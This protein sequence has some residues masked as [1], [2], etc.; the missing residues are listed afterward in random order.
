MAG[1]YA[2]GDPT[3][4][5]DSEKLVQHRPKPKPA[6]KTPVQ[7]HPDEGPW[8]LIYRDMELPPQ[9]DVAHPANNERNISFTGPGS[10]T[11]RLDVDP[12]PAQLSG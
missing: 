2:H 8:R 12:F 1:D 9:V 5:R 11:A 10:L 7:R 4:R 6:S 3:C